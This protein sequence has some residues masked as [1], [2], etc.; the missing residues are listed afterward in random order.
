MRAPFRSGCSRSRRKALPRT[1][2]PEG[3]IRH[4]RIQYRFPPFTDDASLLDAEV[5]DKRED[6][7]LGAH[8]VTLEVVMSNQDGAV[9]AKG[10]VEVE[11]PN[12]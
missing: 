5:V 6:A 2:G 3:F 1:K 10:P 12:P 8:L 4:S 9:L 11:L 7:T